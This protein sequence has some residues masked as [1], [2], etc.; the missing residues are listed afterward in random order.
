LKLHAKARVPLSASNALTRK[1]GGTCF[2][3]DAKLM[4][5][6]LVW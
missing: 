4:H 6:L 3:A 2:C 1:T 5:A